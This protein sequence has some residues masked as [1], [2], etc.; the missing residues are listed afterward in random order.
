MNDPERVWHLNLMMR[1]VNCFLKDVHWLMC[2]MLGSHSQAVPDRMTR[3][4]VQL[5][6]SRL[7]EGEL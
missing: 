2:Q 4:M 7:H 5:S 6:W 3:I 1:V